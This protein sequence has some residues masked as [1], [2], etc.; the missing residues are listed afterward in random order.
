M[1]HPAPLLSCLVI[2]LS[3]LACQVT[4]NLPI[5][6]FRASRE[7]S[8][9]KGICAR[10][11]DLGF[12]I[13]A[14]S[15][16]P[17]C[18]ADC[19]EIVPELGSA[20]AEALVAELTPKHTLCELGVSAETQ[21]VIDRANGLAEEGDTD[22]ALDLLAARM[23]ELDGTSGIGKPLAMPS[24]LSAG[25]DQ[26]VQDLYGMGQAA[27]D[28]GG[29]D[30]PY[31][32]AA[33]SVFRDNATQEMPAADL[34]ETLEIEM[35]AQALGDNEI[36]DQA[37]E[38]RQER[39]EQ[40]YGEAD[41]HVDPC[42]ITPE[43]LKAKLKWAMTAAALDVS[44]TDYNRNPAFLTFVED[45]Q[46]AAQVMKN[47]KAGG[48]IEGCK[49]TGELEITYDMFFSVGTDEP[50]EVTTS[51]PFSLDLTEEPAG[52]Q[53]DVK[54]YDD[55]VFAFGDDTVH[56]IVDFDVNLNFWYTQGSTPLQ[57]DMGIKGGSEFFFGVPIRSGTP[58]I[59]KSVQLD[60]PLTEGA[61][62]EFDVEDLADMKEWKVTLH[63]TPGK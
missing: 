55:Q 40:E 18:S 25:A 35:E 63:L 48:K 58:D 36:A 49:I 44:W 17:T 15:T 10:E 59:D 20:G 16:M 46:R 7:G 12:D 60:F 52:Y 41:A 33:N 28:L 2:V 47:R 19:T 37:H 13:Q 24:R 42:T 34:W 11:P 53:T 29:D 6:G 56:N 27:A 5:P 61:T 22:Q 21:A 26:A 57:V 1:K 30:S 54:L 51:V 39:A 45:I 23:A 62:Q 43:E 38:Q 4:S 14:V 32:N 31:T 8:E 50:I 3:L 9:A